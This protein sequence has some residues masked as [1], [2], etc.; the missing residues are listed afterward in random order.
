M[1]IDQV[2]AIGPAFTEFLRPFEYYLDSPHNVQ[3]FRD[4]TRGLLTDLERTPEE[5]ARI[6]AIRERF[7]RERPNARKLV[8]SGE[9]NPPI[10]ASAY[11]AVAALLKRLREAREAAGLSLADMAER[12][13]MDKAS[14]CRLETGKQSNPTVETLARYAAAM[15]KQVLFSLA[16]VE[17][18]GKKKAGVIVVP[19]E[20]SAAG[21]G[22]TARK[23]RK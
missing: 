15:D 5:Q 9:F 19:K 10:P 17:A 3:H 13:S 21:N 20:Q 8:E 23:A 18:T 2:E 1:T 11:F 22:K 14:L 16:D 4:Y 12:T 7:Q 6:K